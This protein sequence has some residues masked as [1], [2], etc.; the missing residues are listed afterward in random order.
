M[1]TW[2]ITGASRGLGFGLVKQILEASKDNT[3][4]AAC[5][6]PSSAKQLSDLMKSSHSDSL[7]IVKLDVADEVSIVEASTEVGKILARNVLTLD[8][9]INNA[10]LTSGN[11]SPL[12]LRQANFVKTLTTNAVAPMIVSQHFMKFL[13]KSKR[14]VVMNMSSGLGSIENASGTYQTSYCTSKAALNMLTKKLADERKNVIS[15]VMDPGWVKTDLG[16]SAAPF[17]VDFSVSN[18]YKVLV[19]VSAKDSGSFLRFDGQVV[20]W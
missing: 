7:H 19:G 9:L 2:L 8:Y 13:E 11:D 4:F 12:T 10:G 18:V 6:D 17:D 20:P 15:F 1:A 16:G 3:V 5:R 14:P